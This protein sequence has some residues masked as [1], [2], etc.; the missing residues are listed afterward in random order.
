MGAPP[1]FS[2]LIDPQSGGSVSLC[3][4]VPCHAERRYLPDTNVLQTTFGTVGGQVRVTD[5][6][7]RDV[8][9]LLAW[10]ELARTG[11]LG[12]HSRPATCRRR[13]RTWP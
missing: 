9:G 13:C 7:D 12:R 11:G 4:A 8:A 3:P 10:P 2:A 6:V 1:A 5:A